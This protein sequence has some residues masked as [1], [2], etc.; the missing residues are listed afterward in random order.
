MNE[1]KKWPI[2][3][4]FKKNFPKC[5][6]EIRNCPE[7]IYYRGE[8]KDE[9]F[10]KVTAI[11]GSR[12]ITK[13]GR[14]V[15]EK[16]MPEI[17][18]RKSTVISGFMYGVDVQAHQ[19]CLE[20]GG[21]TIAVLGS[22]LDEYYPK[23]NDKLYTEILKNDGLVI[24]EY[25]PNLKPTTWTFP[26][27][28][29]IVSG[30]TNTSVVIIEAGIKS[31]SLITAKLALEQKRRILAVPGMISS[32]MSEGTNWLIKTGGAKILTEPIDIFEDRIAMPTQENLFKDY[33]NLSDLEKII[34]DLIETEAMTSDEI[35]QITKKNIS[36]ISTTLSMMLMKDLLTEEDGK[37]YIS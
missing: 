24:S 7:K 35:C 29:R 14:S 33:S 15:V 23:E 27:R 21:K 37:F 12:Q 26:Q 20:L 17:V 1:W 22:G 18:F 32:K 25:E 4:I 10:K 6:Q 8:W 13:Y 34:I 3:E 36:E 9:L 30:L 19:K 11:V 28:N 5:L 31:G 16:I 2:R